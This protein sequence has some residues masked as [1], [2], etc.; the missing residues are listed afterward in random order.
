MQALTPSICWQHTLGLVRYRF[1]GTLLPRLIMATPTDD[2]TQPEPS[3]DVLAERMRAA[4]A[5]DVPKIY[6]NGFINAVSSGDI[7][8]VLER[9]GQPVAVLNMSFTVAKSLAQALGVTVS[10]LEKK[11]GQAMLTTKDVDALRLEGMKRNF[12]EK[13]T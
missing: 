6:F 1:E 9:N 3:P 5:P 8:T 4:L 10:D 2:E 11:A 13:A 7:V 12:R